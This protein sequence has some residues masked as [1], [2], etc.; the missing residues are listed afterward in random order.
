VC[1]FAE[2]RFEE[3]HGNVQTFV[4]C[5]A[6]KRTTNP[7]PLI[8]AMTVGSYQGMWRQVGNDNRAVVNSNSFGAPLLCWAQLHAWRKM[9]PT[10]LSAIYLFLRE[11]KHKLDSI[12]QCLNMVTELK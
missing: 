9:S 6:R 7:C 1:H 12:S 10:I 5:K 3:T 4:A 8:L 11:S 2:R